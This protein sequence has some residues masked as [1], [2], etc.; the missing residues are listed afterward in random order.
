LDRRLRWRLT[1]DTS[2]Y[3]HAL[4]QPSSVA[5][6]GRWLPDQPWQR[7]GIAAI[8]AARLGKT[9][10]DTAAEPVLFALAANRALDPSSKLAAALGGL[11]G[12]DRPAARDIR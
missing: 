2:G 5:F 4:N 10:R 6:G 8:L 11:Q 7:L 1:V 12:L 3:L 9:R